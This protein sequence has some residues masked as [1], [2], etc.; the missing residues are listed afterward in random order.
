MYDNNYWGLRMWEESTRKPHLV[1]L[2]LDECSPCNRQVKFK[3]S[4]SYSV[5]VNTDHY[6]RHNSELTWASNLWISTSMHK[7]KA[8]MSSLVMSLNQSYSHMQFM[9]QVTLGHHYTNPWKSWA[10]LSAQQVYK[11]FFPPHSG[12]TKCLLQHDREC[13]ITLQTVA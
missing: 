11:R 8:Q 12:N 7:Y 10:V 5:L 3:A 2:V 6:Y 13:G 9:L 1:W 4:F